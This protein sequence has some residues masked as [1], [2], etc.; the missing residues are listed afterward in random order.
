VLILLF[1]YPVRTAVTVAASLAQIGEFSFIL[2]ALG[3]QLGVL[4]KQAYSLILAGALI[5]ISINP[6][7]FR[8]IGPLE[9]ALKKLPLL[10]YLR[11]ADDLAVLTEKAPLRDHVVLV[12]YGRSGKRVGRQLRAENV[13][14]IV[15][16]HNR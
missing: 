10:N 8:L 13:P 14:F 4:P 15:I 5:S 3:L 16:E 11:Q 12:G 7:M 1:R 2:A 6:F 9:H